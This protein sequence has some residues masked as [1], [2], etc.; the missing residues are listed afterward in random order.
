[1]LK[2]KTDQSVNGPLN[3]R[4]TNIVPKTMRT[5][6]IKELKCWI[7]VPKDATPQEAKI[8]ERKYIERYNLD[9]LNSMTKIPLTEIG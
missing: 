2:N 1:M 9:L 4:H 8:R 3:K 6:Y 7:F 5:H